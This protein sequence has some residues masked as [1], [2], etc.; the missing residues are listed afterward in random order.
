MEN[1]IGLSKRIPYSSFFGLSYY[2]ERVI[3]VITHTQLLAKWHGP[4]LSSREQILFSLISTCY[5]HPNIH[6]DPKKQKK[7]K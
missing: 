4:E 7:K 5:T 6:T 1:Y 2:Y 3:L